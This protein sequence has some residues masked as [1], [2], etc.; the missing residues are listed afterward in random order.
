MNDRSAIALC[1][2][3]SLAAGALGALLAAPDQDR[4]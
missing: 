3:L 2:T 1:V 4:V